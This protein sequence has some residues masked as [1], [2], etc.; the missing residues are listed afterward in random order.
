[1]DLSISS[2]N[3]HVDVPPPPSPVNACFSPLPESPDPEL[4]QVHARSSTPD[5]DVMSGV[6]LPGEIRHIS[7]FSAAIA[8]VRVYRV[9]YVHKE[10]ALLA[11]G[12]TVSQ[13]VFHPE[14]PDTAARDK[15][16]GPTN[17]LVSEAQDFLSPVVEAATA[18]GSA[19]Q[20]GPARDHHLSTS[21][22]L[23]LRVQVAQLHLQT[24][25]I[26][27]HIPETAGAFIANKFF[28]EDEESLVMSFSTNECHFWLSEGH[29]T[30]FHFR[31]RYNPGSKEVEPFEL[32]P[33]EFIQALGLRGFS[34]CAQVLPSPSSYPNMWFVARYEPGSG[35]RSD[36]DILQLGHYVLD[37]SLWS[38][39]DLGF[40]PRPLPGSNLF[41]ERQKIFL[42]RRSL[43][44]IFGEARDKWKHQTPTPATTTQ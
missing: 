1:M 23:S 18:Y 25:K 37:G 9:K 20:L 4:A 28:S 24:G 14:C 36:V 2:Q 35:L 26:F 30:M 39:T 42:Q 11:E 7:L 10:S 29:R 8:K 21:K 33:P 34:A 44:L 17:P 41:K 15:L 38:G 40:E 12:F 31:F 6:S 22:P 43:L 5:V 16:L 13:L 27:D 3:V 19:E 32:T